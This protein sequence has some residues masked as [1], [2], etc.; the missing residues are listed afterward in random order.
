M[1]ITKV[2]GEQL[3]SDFL[4][5]NDTPSSYSGLADNLVVVNAGETGIE[6]K[7]ASNA[8]PQVTWYNSIFTLNGTN[9]QFTLDNTPEASSLIATLEGMA[10][11]IGAANDFTVTGTTLTLDDNVNIESGMKLDVNYV[12]ETGTCSGSASVSVGSDTISSGSTLSPDYDYYILASDGGSISLGNP[13]LSGG[14]NGQEITLVGSSDTNYITVQGGNGITLDGPIDLKGNIA[15]R[16]VYLTSLATWVEIAGDVKGLK[17]LTGTTNISWQVDGDNTGP[18]LKNLSGVLQLKN[19]ADTSFYNFKADNIET[20]SNVTVNGDL[21]VNGTTT[22]VNSETLTIDDNIIILNNNVTGTPSENAGIEIERGTSNNV[23][24]RWNE[25]TDTWQTTND[26][27]NFYNILT[28][29]IRTWTEKTST[30]NNDTLSANDN[31]ILNSS[32][33]AFTLNL[34]SSPSSGDMLQFLDGTGDLETNNVTLGR[35]GS[36]IMG[37]AEDLVIDSGD[38]GFKLVYYNAS[39]GWRIF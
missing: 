31:T 1:A 8:V 11:S 10:L 13:Q 9:R 7:T 27:T 16:L 5:L 15:I 37:L 25:T 28:N 32:T 22:T 34:P 26:G 24:V 3:N 36:N 30:N 23:T 35:N 14:F 4:D 33:S 12:S 21:T 29:N 20:V 17:A 38:S 19:E 2:R 39:E 6:F 18:I